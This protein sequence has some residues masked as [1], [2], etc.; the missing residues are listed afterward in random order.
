MRS[1]RWAAALGAI[2]VFGALCARPASAQAQDASDQA[3]APA[4]DSQKGAAQGQG[5][6]SIGFFDTAI[7]G[8]FLRSNFKLPL[9]VV[10]ILGTGFDASYNVSNDWT[11]YGGVRYFTGR[12]NSPGP[13]LNCPT[14]AP[15]QCAGDPPLTP[16]HPESPFLDDGSYHG[17][18]QDWNLG[19][20]YHAN[21]GNY[22]I[23]PSVTAT[24]P[25]HDY[26]TYG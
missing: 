3:A 1:F 9:G 22:S 11:I 10:H 12:N 6:V 26:P 7:N 25:T 13:F 5:S 20:A 8:F 18:W 23:T 17:A 19:V 24:I 14:T 15:P 2:V 4:D 16:Q 21:I